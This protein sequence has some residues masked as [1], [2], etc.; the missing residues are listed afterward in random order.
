MW[1]AIAAVAGA[2]GSIYGAERARSEQK[3]ERRRWDRLYGQTG[4]ERIAKMGE[5]RTRYLGALSDIRGGYDSA[6]GG[7]EAQRVAGRVNAAGAASQ[8]LANIRQN[9]ISRHLYNT[10]A[11][12]AA[13]SRHTAGVTGVLD[14]IDAQA[15]AMRA[16]LAVRRGQALGD[17]QGQLAQLEMADYGSLAD[18]SSKR[19]NYLADFQYANDTDW[20][21]YAGILGAFADQAFSGPSSDQ[22]FEGPDTSGT[23]DNTIFDSEPDNFGLSTTF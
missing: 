5:A 18:L 12:D 11:Y 20:A 7:V 3:Q 22:S 15:E 17:A 6:I 14:Q 10:T 4:S 13:V 16:E 19:M 21:R 8:N 1:G 23:L 9:M 2:A